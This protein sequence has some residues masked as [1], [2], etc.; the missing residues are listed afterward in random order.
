MASTSVALAGLVLAAASAAAS[1]LATEAQCIAD[2]HSASNFS[3]CSPKLPGLNGAIDAVV[4]PDGNYVYA[5][6][7][8]AGEVT[9]FSRHADGT[10]TEIGCFGPND[11]NTADDGAHTSACAKTAPGV[12]GAVGEALSPDGKWLYVAGINDD[13][14]TWF[15]RDLSTGALTWAGCVQD[16]A[17]G[18][19]TAEYQASCGRV[20][21]LNAARWVAISP[22]GR[23]VYVANTGHSVSQFSRDQTTG[24]LTSMGCIKDVN[25]TG[26]NSGGYDSASVANCSQTGSALWY[27]R[28][29]VVSPD[30]TSVYS[31]DNFGYGIAE[32]SRNPTTGALTEVGCI[33]DTTAPS[34]MGTCARRTPSLQ[35]I[36]SVAI[37]ADGRYVYAGGQT[38]QLTVLGR[39][40]STSLLTPLSCVSDPSTNS[41]NKC[42]QTQVDMKDIVG[43][44]LS[45]NGSQ[46]W[47]ANFGPLNSSEQFGLVGFTVN[48]TTGSLTPIGCIQDAHESTNPGCAQTADGLYGTR[49]A[50]FSP[51]GTSM[52]TTA[53]VA[54]TLAT[55]TGSFGA[56]A[57]APPVPPACAG[58]GVSTAYATAVAG[59]LTCVDPNGSNGLSFALASPPAHGSASVTATGSFRYTPAQGFSGTDS[60]TVVGTDAHGSSAPAT[61]TVA[62]AAPPPPPPI[63]P[64]LVSCA[65]TP[66]PTPPPPNPIVF[67]RPPRPAPNPPSITVQSR[68]VRPAGRR[69]VVTLRLAPG[70][71]VPARGRAQ[72]VSAAGRRRSF[73][74]RWFT[75]SA[76]RPVAL[77]LALPP[78]LARRLAAGKAK[79]RVVLQVGAGTRMRY[80][81]SACAVRR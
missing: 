37:S 28:E 56:A 57:S 9:S 32:F 38:G 31:T 68:C 34:Y 66:I 11:Y 20:T 25:N 21:N 17:Y 18:P 79:L 5:T 54:S 61:V 1:P 33:S 51:D 36:F 67:P 58:A 29:I 52:Y 63:T 39:D 43:V 50:T 46:L 71:L 53:S 64:C 70:S 60:F 75:V 12:N 49:R 47:A 24:A 81:V 42:A 45:P 16:A 35:W 23:N 22:D 27:N 44:T 78:S 72:L 74:A 65:P 76:G 80:P 59:Q 73:A 40:P 26:A 48:Q 55:F 3:Q 69:A 19:G 8:S 6:T 30:G 15:S 2:T 10:L 77:A 4:S 62:V 41:I 7:E 14:I 13:A